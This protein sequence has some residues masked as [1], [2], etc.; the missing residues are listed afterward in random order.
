MRVIPVSTQALLEAQTLVVRDFMRITARVRDTGAPVTEGFWSD[1][2]D[3]SAQVIDADTGLAT[4]Y[5]FKGVGALIAIDP[6]PM[7]SNLTVQEVGVQFS[8][9]G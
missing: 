2:G 7:V 1:L 8:P 9:T 6:I 5:D 4:S 3:V